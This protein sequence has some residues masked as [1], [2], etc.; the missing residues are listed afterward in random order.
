MLISLWSQEE[1]RIIK[2][3][4]V[5]MRNAHQQLKLPQNL[6]GGAQTKVLSLH[7]EEVLPLQ[8]RNKDSRSFWDLTMVLTVFLII[9]KP[10]T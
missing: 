5:G 6:S 10:K 8:T 1:V 2:V 9:N 3:E 7:L 4:L